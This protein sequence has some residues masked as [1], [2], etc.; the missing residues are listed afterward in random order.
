MPITK[1]DIRLNIISGEVT[2]YSALP[3]ASSVSGQF[4]WVN[5]DQGTSWIPSWLGGN[6]YP[7]GTYHSNGTT[8]DYQSM[9]SNATLSTVDA[10]TNTDQFVTP[11]TLSNS[12]WAFTYDKVRSTVLTGLNTLTNAAI[13]ATDTVLTAF[14]KL[15]AR[16]EQWRTYGWSTGAISGFSLTNNGD[17]TANIDSGVVL[18]RTTASST[19]T[20]NEYTI[21]ATSGLTFTDNATNYI[22]ADYNGGTPVVSVITDST[23]I[24][25]L[26]TTLIYSVVR[27]GTNLYYQ[28]VIGQN[29]DSNGKLRRRFLLTE[30]FEHGTGVALSFSNRNV[31]VTAGNYF[32]GLT[33][34]STPAFDTTGSGTF[35]YVYYNGSGYTRTTGQTQIN[36]STYISAG[37]PVAMTGN[38]FRVDYMYLLIDN[39]TQLWIVQGDAEYTSFSEAQAAPIPS[40]LPPELVGLGELIGRAIIRNAATVLYDIQSAYENQFVGTAVATHNQLAGLQGGT[41]DEYYHLTASEYTN[42][43]TANNTQTLTNKRITKRVTTA[44]TAV[45]LT[46]NADTEDVTILT[47]LASALTINAPTGTPTSEQE[48]DFAFTDNG[49]A[50]ALTWNGVFVSYGAAIPT[51]TVANKRLTVKA[52]WIASA[53]VWGCVGYV[54]QP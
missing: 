36:N 53:S 13:S 24:N 31:I 52:R 9:P 46:P 26:T 44:A 37:T 42:L 21:S 54:V 15:S 50:R 23:L 1:D 8:W 27:Q 16:L 25:T 17:G 45:S 14:G 7:K 4:Y 5:N 29:V 12:V 11:Y 48:L 20:L 41:T 33:A 47:A 18:L 2:N 32:I 34:V 3:A 38:K 43:T 30:R 51:T 10:G 22:I 6:F 19:G 35:T 40:N 28:N 39:P 49:T